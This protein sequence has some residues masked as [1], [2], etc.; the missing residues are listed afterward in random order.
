MIEQ[1]VVCKR[2]LETVLLGEC[3]A[4]SFNRV[5]YISE[6]NRK[7][8][9]ARD[10]LAYYCFPNLVFDTSSG[11]VRE[12]AELIPGVVWGTFIPTE[13]HAPKPYGTVARK[14]LEEI[15]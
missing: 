8:R 4:C 6:L 1:C 14:A 3:T 12:L 11:E 13:A 9:I 7:L 5:S 15:G 10:A 2:Y